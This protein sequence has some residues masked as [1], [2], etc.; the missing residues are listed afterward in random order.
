MTNLVSSYLLNSHL[1]HKNST[2]FPPSPPPPKKSK[3]KNKKNNIK[4]RTEE[5]LPK[6][7]IQVLVACIKRL[8]V[9]KDSIKICESKICMKKN[10]F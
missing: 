1:K 5:T 9:Y 4:L 7:V 3:I 8:D 10:L 6:F 2:N